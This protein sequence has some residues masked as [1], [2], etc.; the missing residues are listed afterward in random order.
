MAVGFDVD[1]F[2]RVDASA[3]RTLLHLAGTFTEGAGPH[4]PELLVDDGITRQRISPLPGA[5]APHPD[6][7]SD[8]RATFPVPAEL[9]ERASVGYALS[10]SEAEVID[11]PAPSV[12][13]ASDP[14][15]EIEAAHRRGLQA[16]ARGREEFDVLAEL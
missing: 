16:L 14:D 8:W 3:E 6:A 2:E 10:T 7:E 13:A 5:E 15:P 11:L 12:P 4:T 9:I 1:L